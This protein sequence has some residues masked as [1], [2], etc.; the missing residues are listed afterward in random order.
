MQQN[1]YV[2]DMPTSEPS[3]L[4]GPRSLTPSQSE[5]GQLV[6]IWNPRVL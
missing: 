1:M 6:F 3:C 2:H 4:A 5:Q